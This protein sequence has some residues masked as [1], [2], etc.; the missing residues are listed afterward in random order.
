MTSQNQTSRMHRWIPLPS[1]TVY[2][3]RWDLPQIW[4]SNFRKMAQRRA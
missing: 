2:S 3:C 1:Y 4:T